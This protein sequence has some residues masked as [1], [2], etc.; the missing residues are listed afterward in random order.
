MQLHAKIG[1]QVFFA[2]MMIFVFTDIGFQNEGGLEG[3]V[4][5]DPKK[6]PGVYNQQ[7]FAAAYQFFGACS[8]LC[9]N[10]M[11]NNAF[12]TLL[13]FIMERAVFLRE[14]SNKLYGVFPYF[15]SKNV[16]ELPVVMINPLLL[17][18]IIYFAFGFERSF[19]QFVLVYLIQFLL[20]ACS[21]S[22]G[23]MI[24]AMFT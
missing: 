1:Q 20:S 22:L 23:Y 2:I 6:N 21:Q 19:E 18:I 9:I 15:I 11:F 10:T 5:A 24:S 7:L 14:Q 3:K 4:T 16:V 12:N 17:T 8:F 13:V